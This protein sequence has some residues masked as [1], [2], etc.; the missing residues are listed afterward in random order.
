MPGPRAIR[1]KEGGIAPALGFVPRQVRQR[2]QQLLE[3]VFVQR[4][5]EPPRVFKRRIAAPGLASAGYSG[6]AGF[7]QLIGRTMSAP[8]LNVRRNWPG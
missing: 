8:R 6:N 4:A 5:L 2:P 1:V 3:V 7:T